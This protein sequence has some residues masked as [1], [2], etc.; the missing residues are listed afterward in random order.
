MNEPTSLSDIIQLLVAGFAAIL[1]FAVSAEALRRH[2]TFSRPSALVV[3]LCAAG[4]A[5]ISLMPALTGSTGASTV[6]KPASSPLVETILLPYAALGLALLVLF[7]RWPPM[8]TSGFFPQSRVV[9]RDREAMDKVITTFR[10]PGDMGRWMAAED[11]GKHPDSLDALLEVLPE[12]DIDLMLHICKALAQIKDKRAVR[13]L[14]DRWATVPQGAPAMQYIP[15]AL[16]AIGDTSVVP[17][18]VAPLHELRF[19]YRFHIANA[20]GELG[21]KEAEVALKDLAENDPFPAIRQHAK[22][23]LEK[24]A[25]PK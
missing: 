13:P 15:D 20:L 2:S 7:V 12:A 23:M 21:G 17:A 1:V 24:L 4:L 19:A 5:A 16:G 10:A 22:E 3:A 14:L 11:L 6:A 9:L 18:L 8:Q 25:Q